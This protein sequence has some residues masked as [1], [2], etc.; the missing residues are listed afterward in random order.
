MV[1]CNTRVFSDGI[2]PMNVFNTVQLLISGTHF[3]FRA[4]CHIEHMYEEKLS[5]M[6][7]TTEKVIR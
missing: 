7:T 2:S 4:D 6:K 3:L 1:C 5:N